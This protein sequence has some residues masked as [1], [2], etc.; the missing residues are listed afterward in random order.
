MQPPL[1]QPLVVSTDLSFPIQKKE[2]KRLPKLSSDS[3]KW[4]SP[5]L[6][7]QMGRYPQLV[8]GINYTTLG[9]KTE[10]LR[11]SGN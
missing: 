1:Q 8:T 4:T 11:R 2:V 7:F 6:E 10:D 3:G 9:E 5:T